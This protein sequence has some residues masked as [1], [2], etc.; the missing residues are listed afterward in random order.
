MG[1]IGRNRKAKLYRRKVSY[2]EAVVCDIELTRRSPGGWL[3]ASK[4]LIKSGEKGLLL[5]KKRERYTLVLDKSVGG[6]KAFKIVI[7]SVDEDLKSG[8]FDIL[9]RE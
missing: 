4:P 7:T 2:D 5:P 6:M 1:L 8:A 3:F 9:S